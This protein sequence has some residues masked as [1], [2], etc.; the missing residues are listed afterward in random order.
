MDPKCPYGLSMLGFT[1]V[2]SS[3][4][5]L[6]MPCD[7]YELQLQNGVVTPNGNPEAP[8]AYLDQSSSTVFALQH[9]H[10]N[11]VLDH[12]SILHTDPN[13]GICSMSCLEMMHCV[14]SSWFDQFTLRFPWFWTPRSRDA[15]RFPTSQQHHLCCGAWILG[16]VSSLALH[17][18][19]CLEFWQLVISLGW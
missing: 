19:K 5:E 4:P 8:V 16:F 13:T 6:S 18:D 14:C 17:G 10:T 7:Q 12:K 1:P 15:G 11:I 9:G 3:L 2:S